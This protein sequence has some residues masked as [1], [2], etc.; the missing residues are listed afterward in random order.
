[1][2]WDLRV[3]MTPYFLSSNNQNTISIWNDLDRGMSIDTDAVC[4]CNTIWSLMGR[5]SVDFWSLNELRLGNSDAK[6]DLAGLL[7]SLISGYQYHPS[8]MNLRHDFI[9]VKLDKRG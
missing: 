3:D 9:N 5:D 1:M 7:L 6:D 4:H 8:R 2:A